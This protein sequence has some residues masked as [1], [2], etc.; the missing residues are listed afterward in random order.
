MPVPGLTLP[1]GK[2]EK[3]R[4]KPPLDSAF[5][6]FVIPPP[7]YPMVQSTTNAFHNPTPNSSPDEA[8]AATVTPAPP[9]PSPRAARDPSKDPTSLSPP[10]SPIALPDCALDDTTEPAPTT[11]ASLPFPTAGN[12]FS[13]GFADSPVLGTTGGNAFDING[14]CEDF[15]NE[16]V[17]AYL[18]AV[19]GGGT[20]VEMIRS[21]LALARLPRVKL[22]G[23]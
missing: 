13:E 18:E 3:E 9:S 17:I 10:L 2:E 1:T 15:V 14:I 23:S 22:V 16:A 4:R 19:P 20:W 7:A 21:Y 11:P 12:L 5:P 6:L 8:V